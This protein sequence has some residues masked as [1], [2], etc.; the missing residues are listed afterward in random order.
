MVTGTTGVPRLFDTQLLARRRKKAFAHHGTE[1]D[2]LLKEVATD[3]LDRLSIILRPFPLIAELGGHTGLLAQQLKSRQGTDYVLRLEQGSSLL[4]REDHGLVF[5][6]E[7]LPLKPQSLN[8]LVSPLFLHWVNDLPGT[9]LQIR[10]SLAPDGLLLA[11]LLGRESLKELREAFLI[12]DSEISG[13]ASPR[14]APL[15][16]LKDMG[17]LLQRAGFTLPVVDHDTLTVRYSS[18]F[19][20]MQD[21]R[22]MGA[23]NALTD[24]SRAFMRRDCLMRAAEIYQERFSDPDG[25]VR[26]TFQ[27]LSLSGWAPDESQQKPLKPGSAK[28]SL[29]S[30]LGDKSA[31]K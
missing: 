15:P 20:L 31:R 2:F 10:Q 4:G 9:L 24:R 12:A 7:F 16:D 19:S 22:R 25:R 8:L 5:D 17:N 14:V 30:V 29:A 23:T 28:L 27:I 18:L 6:P 3:M 13:G 21:L 1:G 11:T 26:A